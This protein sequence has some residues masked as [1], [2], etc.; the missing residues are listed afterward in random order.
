MKEEDIYAKKIIERLN[1]SPIDKS[2]EEKLNTIR[3]LALE[4]RKIQE[5]IEIK[6]SAIILKSSLF[7]Y[8]YE[9]IVMM[10]VLLMLLFGVIF[11]NTTISENLS[12]QY[13]EYKRDLN[14][15]LEEHENWKNEMEDMIEN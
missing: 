15:D 3:K 12:I 14:K 8:T 13:M 1:D 10:L 4:K 2:I 11:K 7:N 6:D 9:S 5:E